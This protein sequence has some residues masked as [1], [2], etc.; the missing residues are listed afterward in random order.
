MLTQTV[1]L[2]LLATVAVATPLSAPAGVGRISG[3]VRDSSG[4][5]LAGAQVVIVGTRFGAVTD[6][7]GT[8]TIASVPEGA[9]SVRAMFIGYA[10]LEVHGIR[11]TTDST[12][13]ADFGPGITLASPLTVT[14]PT[15]ATAVL[16]DRK[17]TR[18]NSSH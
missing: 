10:P 1:R 16:K 6:R 4:H 8:Y 13:T 17:S 12:T 9:Y 7:A 18:L 14:S 2:I 3:H 15:I 5:P 11:V